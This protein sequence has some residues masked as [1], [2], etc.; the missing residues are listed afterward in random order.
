MSLSFQD[1][2]EAIYLDDKDE[3]LIYQNSS[4]RNKR[5]KRG[6]LFASK[7]VTVRGKFIDAENGNDVGLVAAQAGI[8]A[9]LAQ[10]TAD[11]AALSANGRNRIF[12]QSTAPTSPVN[13]YE[14]INGDMWFNTSSIENYAMYTWNTSLAGAN[15]WEL[16]EVGDLS[17]ARINAG[18]IVAGFIG[19]Q[20]IAINGTDVYNNPV[21]AGGYIESTSFVLTWPGPNLV[22]VRAY[23]AAATNLGKNIASDIVQAKKLTSDGSYRLFR[24]KANQPKSP[25]QIG[26]LDSGWE[27]YWDEITGAS[28]PTI[29]IP[30]TTTESKSVQNFGFRIASNGFA[31]FSGAIFRGAIV[32]NEGFFGTTVNAIRLNDKGLTVGNNGYLKSA[33]IGYNGTSGVFTSSSGSGGFF[34][35]NTQAEGVTPEVYQFFI[36]DPS[37]NSLR[38]N[39][40]DLRI[41]GKL[42]A[43]TEVGLSGDSSFGLTINSQFGIRRAVSNGTLTITGGDG[44]GVQ[45]G[46]QI[47]LAGSFLNT[48]GNDTGN[49]QLSLQAAYNASNN[50]N[51]PV[52]GSI[53]FRTSKFT[54]VST[55]DVG[56]MRMLIALD[57]TVL[58]GKGDETASGGAPNSGSGKLIVSTSITSGGADLFGNNT[59]GLIYVKNNSDSAT[60]T[61][62]GTS[63]DVSASQFTTSS[64]KRVKTNIKKLKNGLD[65]VQKL[66]P[67]SF[68]RKGKGGKND[69]GL[70]AEEV[71]KILPEVTG[72]DQNGQISGLDYSKL[73]AVLIQA[74]KELSVEV[75]RLKSKIK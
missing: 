19:S 41:N 70:I 26:P 15:K 49:G 69:I 57:G 12:Y 74:V 17:I 75:D 11:G 33:G 56:I 35:G 43:G 54:T 52:D 42:L 71:D 48:S 18:K 29:S 34:L 2:Q 55:A 58:I 13:G 53:V 40:T 3:F 24:S 36:G 21:G 50:F 72:K 6:N 63:G 22:E 62:T 4:Q 14:L 20:V 9:G 37:G 68:K 45:Y 59:N 31:E 64:S 10:S 46:A 27:T 51:G 23:N 30:I 1:L 67:V 61:L 47:D 5:V 66:N 32:S 60:I 7:G 28:I 38:W 65:T 73:T 39:G 25:S 8:N 16:R 44:N